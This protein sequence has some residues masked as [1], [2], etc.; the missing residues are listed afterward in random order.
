MKKLL[1]A[2]LLSTAM[3]SQTTTVRG[4]TLHYDQPN[5]T[6]VLTIPKDAIKT[7]IKDQVQ[8]IITKAC[9]LAINNNIVN[10]Y[11]KFKGYNQGSIHGMEY[12]SIVPL[13]YDSSS[14]QFTFQFSNVTPDE[15]IIEVSNVQS[16]DKQSSSIIIK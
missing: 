2:L 16:K 11:F 13:Y 5:H 7:T 6:M 14:K 1:L 12:E 10:T 8:I 3:Y 4:I 15:Y 9:S